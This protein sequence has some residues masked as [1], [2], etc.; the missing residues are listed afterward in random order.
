MTHMPSDKVPS[1]GPEPFDVIGSSLE[2][3]LA[4]AARG[5]EQAF[6]SLYDRTASRVYGMVLRVIR[7]PAQ[8]AEVTQDVYLEVW[9]QSTRFDATKSAVVPWLLLIAHRRAVDRVRSAQSAA[10]RDN[11][12]IELNTERPYDNVSE[13]V[14]TTLEA[15]RVRKVMNDLTDAQ[16]EA[17]SLAYFGGYTHNEVA[18]L[19]NVPLGTVKTRIRDGL[20]RLRDALGVPS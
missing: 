12:Y 4:A 9:R 1:V 3:L 7:D 5:N 10:T 15:Q 8:A 14:E 19:L 16:R 18:E 20:I 17:V 6:A 13:Q 2:G 11:R